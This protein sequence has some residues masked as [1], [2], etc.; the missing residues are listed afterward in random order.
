MSGSMQHER[1]DYI[2]ATRMTRNL[3]FK[4]NNSSIAYSVLEEIKVKPN[5]TYLC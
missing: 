5:V 4:L 2:S 1:Y 3:N